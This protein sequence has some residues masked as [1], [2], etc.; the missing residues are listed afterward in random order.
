M[1]ATQHDQH[2]ADTLIQNFEGW[3]SLV[4]PSPCRAIAEHPYAQRP[5]CHIRRWLMSTQ[6]RR[7]SIQDVTSND[8]AKGNAILPMTHRSRLIDY[9]PND[10]E[11]MRSL[12]VVDWVMAITM[13]DT[14]PSYILG[15]DFW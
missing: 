13:P 3:T 11:A 4:T 12:F 14:L 2:L 9:I 7:N 10:D 5:V 6:A 1:I 8:G 15:L